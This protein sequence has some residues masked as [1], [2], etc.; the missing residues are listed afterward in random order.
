ME[1]SFFFGAMYVSYA[2]G[3]AISL[4]IFA[5]A[6]LLLN[7]SLVNSIILLSAVL[8]LIIPLNVRLSRNIWI[9]LFINYDSKSTHSNS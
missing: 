8:F 3:V 1:P 6:Y 7:F 2:I 9:N 5:L 4:S